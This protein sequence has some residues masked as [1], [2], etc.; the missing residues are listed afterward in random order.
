MKKIA[1]ILMTFWTG[2][3]W[4]E[5]P[6][7]QSISNEAFAEG[8][9]LRYN[10]YYNWKSV[11]AKAG[12]VTF[13]IKNSTIQ[14]KELFHIKAV[15]KT[16]P[17][18]SWF[19]KV[20]DVYE[21]YV[22]KKTSLPT[23]FV[24]DVNE[25]GF[26]I[27]R[28]Y[29]FN[30]ETQKLQAKWKVNKAKEQSKTFDFNAC[31]HDMLSAIYKMRSID[32]TQLKIGD[33]V[34]VEVFLDNEMYQLAMIFK[35]HSEV[36]TKFGVVR[37]LKVEPRVISGRVFDE[38]KGVTIHVSNDANKV[39]VLIEAPISVGSVKAILDDYEQLKNITAMKK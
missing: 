3:V 19:Y 4:A 15:G 36:D 23:K 16:Y 35:G 28:Q 12:F 11:W 37:C 33:E 24:R 9:H 32:F 10:V 1:I 29:D 6:T 25:G 39:P 31:T 18:Y 14:N 34:P 7:C 17:F 13:D 20:H 21:T 26:K 2:I 30:R 22:D 8:E 27:D 38:E 5:Q